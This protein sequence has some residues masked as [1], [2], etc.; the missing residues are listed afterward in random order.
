MK[1]PKFEYFDPTTVQEALDLLK[2]YGEDAKLLA[3]GQSLVPLLNFRLAHPQVLIDINRIKEMDY[4]RE[5]NGKLAIGAMT[6]Q[7]TLEVSQTIRSKCGLLTD[8]A[9]LI[10]HPQIRNRGTVGGS[11]AH[12]DP[13][14]ELTAIAKALDADMKVRSHEGERTIPAKDFFVTVMTTALEPSEMLVEIE[15]PSLAPSAGWA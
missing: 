13:T 5:A 3:G 9:E 10:G 11:L 8:S 12:A 15:F 2:Q 6:R 7:R 1:P 4:V 14:A